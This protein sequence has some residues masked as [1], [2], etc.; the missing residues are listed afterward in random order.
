MAKIF[1]KTGS[2]Q[3]PRQSL[4]FVRA[5]ALEGLESI[6]R[7]SLRLE[8]AFRVEI[9]SSDM[10]ILFENPGTWFDGARVINEFDPDGVPRPGTRDRIAG[11]TEV[12]LW[13][14]I[15]GGLGEGRRTEILLK[16]KVVLEK[17][18]VGGGDQE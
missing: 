14:S 1:D 11:T 8:T 5:M 6:V 16:A 3:S 17:D 7:L 15:C 9:T 10:A 2:F 18:V 13:K 12:G 4:G